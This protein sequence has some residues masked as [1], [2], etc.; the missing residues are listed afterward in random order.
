[1]AAATAN[2]APATFAE[3]VK[4]GQSLYGEQCASCHGGSGKGGGAPAV[5][6]I[7]EGA[8]PLA[9]PPKAK[10]RKVEFKTVADV[11][12]YVVEAM[13]PGKAGSL[14]TEQYFAILAFDLEA[15]GIH[16]DQKLDAPLAATLV[17]PR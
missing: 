11:A 8:L 3:Q 9:P 12:G 4:L 7:A 10:S 14:T 15:N 2:A 16:L 6:G 5:V 13:P 17:I 1:M